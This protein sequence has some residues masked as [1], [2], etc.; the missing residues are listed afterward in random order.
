MTWPQIAF[1]L[2]LDSALT[3]AW[4]R[5]SNSSGPVPKALELYLWITPIFN[6]AGLGLIHNAV[7]LKALVPAGIVHLA[8]LGWA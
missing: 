5:Y 6:L 2:L 3:P 7:G 8:I 1:A 4:Y